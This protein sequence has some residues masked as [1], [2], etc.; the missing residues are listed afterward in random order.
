MRILLLGLLLLASRLQA[1]SLPLSEGT[2][3]HIRVEAEGIYRIDGEW[4]RQAGVDPATLS[5]E[6]LSLWGMPAGMLP[7]ANGS[8]PP[9]G[10]Q[11]QA[12]WMSGN[13]QGSWQAADELLFYAPGPHGQGYSPQRGFFQETHLYD[14]AQY[15]VLRIGNERGKPLPTATLP[16]PAQGETIGQCQSLQH[17]EVDAVHL[18][19]KPSGRL[20]VSNR[21]NPI[22]SHTFELSAEQPLPG[23]PLRMDL[24]LVAQ[25]R[26]ES[27]F[28]VQVNGQ[29]AGTLTMP[30]APSFNSYVYGPQGSLQDHSLAFTPA[31]MPTDGKWKVALTYRP[32]HADAAGWL[33]YL[34]LQTTHPLALRGNQTTWLFPPAQ[35]AGP[36]RFELPATSLRIWEVSPEGALQEIPT[37]T[38]DGYTRFAAL[39]SQQQPLRLRAFRPQDVPA[40]AYVGRIGNQQLAAMPVPE[41]LIVCAPEYQVQA[42]RLAAFR[43]QHNGLQVGVVT[44]TQVYREFSGGAQ[45]VTAVRN[46]CRSLYARDKRLRYLLLFGAATYDYRGIKYSNAAT[47]PVYESRESLHPIFSFS[48][49]DYFGFLEAGE[50]NWSEEYAP[51]EPEHTLELGVGRLPVRSTEEADLIVGQLIDYAHKA[52]KGPLRQRVLFVADDGDGNIHQEQANQLAELLEQQAPDWLVER[53]LLDAYPK[54]QLPNGARSPLATQALKQHAEAGMSIIN[55]SGHGSETGWTSEQLLTVDD[56]VQWKNMYRQPVLLTATCEFGRY[57]NPTGTS[58][59]QYGL[60]SRNGGAIALLTTTRPVTSNTNFLLNKAFY[61]A[62]LKAEKPV[63][64]GDLVRLTKN[65]SISGVSNR[66]F[67]LLGDPSM[68]LGMPE[69]GIQ[70]LSLDG[71]ALSGQDTLRAQQQ[72]VLEAQVV[73][74]GQADASFSGMAEVRLFGQRSRKQ[75][76]GNEGAP[77]VYHSRSDV[78]FRS[79]VPVKDGRISAR[80]YVPK[81]IQYAYGPARLHL[82]A[83]SADSSRDAIGSG[84][85]IVLGGSMPIPPTDRTPPAIALSLPAAGGVEPPDTYATIDLWDEGG[86]NISPLGIGQDIALSLDGAAPW[87]LNDLYTAQLGQGGRILFPLQ[88]LQ[89][90]A[91]RLVL[92]AWDNAG[93]PATRTLD[94]RVSAYKELPL[95]SLALSPNPMQDVA[96]LQLRQETEGNTLQLSMQ[97]YAMDGTSLGTV[98]EK[99]YQASKEELWEW[100]RPAYWKPGIYLCVVRV[101]ELERGLELQ[102]VFKVVIGRP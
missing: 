14:R 60:L 52:D 17:Y 3:L 73:R 76:L 58:G 48:S 38:Q 59:A 15:F 98:L 66:N 75:T 63:R 70:L 86:I 55:F 85:D 90:G 31:Q 91:H 99:R 29:A 16:I 42:E 30:S 95:R 46:L 47:V 7:Q 68:A 25:A 22:N 1:Q 84:Q 65:N 81:N 26:T 71:R 34:S 93:N 24:Q 54:Q 18:L 8:T 62:L 67:A 51:Q 44:T 56:L 21:F 2:L 13:R 23:A 96:R 57:D 11:A 83:C 19:P 49:D 43:R 12:F 79:K 27:S 28:D 32:P 89:E 61:D 69:M 36:A 82:Y 37:S 94:F 5:K 80:I 10:L 88:G 53:L 50:G 72:V 35:A 41:L 77:F 20:W 74:G 64:L 97:W 102:K 9:Q 4:L 39:R 6:Q 33:D 40:P 92:K 87:V 100:R 101:A 78:L 45:D